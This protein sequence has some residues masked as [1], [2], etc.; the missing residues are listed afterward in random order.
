MTLIVLN[1][2]HYDSQTP[3][4]WK[5]PFKEHTF[6]K[7]E[8]V[9][10]YAKERKAPLLI[11]G[12][13]FEKPDQPIQ[14]LTSLIN[15]A[16]V[17]GVQTYLCLGQHD[18]R[19]HSSAEYKTSAVSVLESTGMFTI[20]SNGN[21]VE[22]EGV[23]IR[24]YSFNDPETEM[25]LEG[26]DDD[27]EDDNFHIA[28]V[29]ASVGADDTMH[30]KGISKQ[31]IRTAECSV[32]GDI[33]DEYWTH[34][35]ENGCVAFGLGGFG[36]R[37]ITDKGRP[38]RILEIE[39]DGLEAQYKVVT[40]PELPDEDIF[41]TVEEQREDSEGVTGEILAQIENM[42]I[43]LD[44]SSIGRVQRYGKELKEEPKVIDLLLQHLP[45]E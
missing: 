6:A 30:S 37:H 24:G 21:Q 28:L 10:F 19:G 35:F 3:A 23:T 32:F 15:L 8:Y 17:T 43:G 11:A 20:L 1:D 16:R 42:S 27:V 44:E 33:H 36:R 14:I 2:V 4:A 39:V 34:E 41:R 18:T 45:K 29:H 40:V 22:L 31:R 26:I 5:V 13:L 12:D 38:S 7:L 9:Y 25:F